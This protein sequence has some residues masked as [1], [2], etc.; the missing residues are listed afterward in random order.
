MCPLAF[1]SS[2]GEWSKFLGNSACGQY[3]CFHV[4]DSNYG[5]DMKTSPIFLNG[6]ALLHIKC[7]GSF[8]NCTTTFPLKMGDAFLQ[9]PRAKPLVYHIA[10]LPV[11]LPQTGGVETRSEE[12]LTPE[13]VRNQMT[14][15]EW[16]KVYD[17]SQD[18]N[19]YA[20]LCSSLFPTIHGEYF[21]R[22]SA[23]L[24]SAL[25]GFYQ[26]SQ[27]GVDIFNTLPIT[28][29]NLVIASQ[30]SIETS[31]FFF[32]KKKGHPYTYG[33]IESKSSRLS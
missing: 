19:L 13:M 23:L 5:R 32:L 21:A 27:C 24:P 3:N 30:S 4:I 7:G 11:V 2:M 6:T 9:Q 16:Q 17:M 14:E 20:N 12:E 18:K 28:N 25:V 29:G 31:G 33:L 26:T 1:L 8:S 10:T 15:A 22:P